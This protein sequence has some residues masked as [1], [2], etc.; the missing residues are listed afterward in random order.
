MKLTFRDY[1]KSILVTGYLIGAAIIG[2]YIGYALFN[3]SLLPD[4]NEMF[5]ITNNLTVFLVFLICLVFTAGVVYLAYMSINH[6]S[7]ITKF[8]SKTNFIKA[9]TFLQLMMHNYRKQ[10]LIYIL[11]TSILLIT[12]FKLSLIGTGFLAFPDE[13][14]YC[15]SG[16]ALHYFSE[17]KISSAIK[18]F[19]STQGRPADALL[20]IIPI[21]VQ[22]VT[23]QLFNLNCYESSNSYPL[24]IFNFIIYCLILIIHYK[25]SK[26]LLKSCFLALMSVLLFSILT[27]SYIYLR[28][29]LPY[30]KSL[31]VYYVI[32]YNV[33]L[34]TENNSLSSMKAFIIGVCSFLGFL[35]YPGYF[36]LL[37]VGLFILFFNNIS[38]QEVFK[39][40]VYSSYYILGSITCL[41]IFEKIARI[42]GKSY[43]LDSIGLSKT[44]TQGSYE[45][46]FSYILKYLFEVEGLTGIILLIS[47]PLFCFIMI[48]Q[49]KHKPF[50]QYSLIMLLS[51]SLIGMFLSYASAGYFLHKVVFY[52]RLLHQYFPFIC[53]FAIYSINEL[54]IKLTRKN[55]LILITISIIFIVNFGFNLLNYNSLAY[56]RDIYWQLVK[57]N[58]LN[59]AGNCF[60]YDDRWPVMPKRNDSINYDIREKR[61]NTIQYI[62]LDG[63]FINASIYLVKDLNEYHMFNPNDNYH[64]LESKPSF[65]N[66]KAY[67]YDSGAN[68]IDRHSMDKNS[69]KINIFSK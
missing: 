16:I 27:N 19:F 31:L 53:I 51:I 68:M 41:Y 11:I 22:S 69:I 63:N 7:K 47:L 28:H 60:E 52:G 17:L 34:Y 5:R 8:I 48:Y 46:S 50:K 30:D 44:I 12:V 14:R 13:I 20:N 2:F 37:F 38:N 26:L 61:I 39:K 35:I 15:Q 24:F 4:K 9:K 42:V 32:L 36:P 43:I 33:A 57:A 58:K 55:E 64:L 40:L 10:P 25:F 54:L 18:V 29:A 6:L 23:S 66:F 59:Y 67:Q 56:P 3:I 45:E 65:M 49:I 1:I 21:A 62:I